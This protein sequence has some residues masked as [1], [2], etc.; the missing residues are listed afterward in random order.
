MMPYRYPLSLIPRFQLENIFINLFIIVLYM[1]DAI[2]HKMKVIVY[3]DNMLWHR[4]LWQFVP[5]SFSLVVRWTETASVDVAM[6]SCQS[7]QYGGVGVLW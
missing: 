5:H 4:Q 2:T 3:I 6:I 1:Y 7:L